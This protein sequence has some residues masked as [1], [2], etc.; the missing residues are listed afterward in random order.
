V[1][2]LVFLCSW[3]SAAQVSQSENNG[4]AAKDAPSVEHQ[5]VGTSPA[6]A[7]P[8]A[9]HNEARQPKR[10]LGI[11]PNYRSVSANTKLPPLSFHEKIRLATQ[12]SFDYSSFILAG[13]LAGA[14]KVQ[15]SYPEFQRGAAA[16]GRYYWHSYTDQVIGNYLSEAIVPAIAGEDP[17][18]YTLGHGGFFVRAGY[19][20][21]RLFVT[22]SNS[23]SRR[24]NFSEIAGN[25]IGAGLSDFYYPAATRTWTKTQQ[26]WVTQVALD[27]VFNVFKEFWPDINRRIL[28]QH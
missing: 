18:Y 16:Y 5:G 21:S 14:G 7:S 12:D 17:R 3:G 13:M 4:T 26:K 20:T 24:F 25:G 15:R 8:T 27:G 28:R 2:V 10:I 1:A 9:P 19:A 23:N 11:I 6:S 22:K